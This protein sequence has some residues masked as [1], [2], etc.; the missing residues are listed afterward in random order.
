MA[1]RQAFIAPLIV[2]SAFQRGSHRLSTR[3]TRPPAIA[4][5]SLSMV[6]E[7]DSNTQSKPQPSIVDAADF[8]AGPPPKHLA[9]DPGVEA[10][11]VDEVVDQSSKPI[12]PIASDATKFDSPQPSESTNS[13]SPVTPESSERQQ[14]LQ[15]QIKEPESS[16]QNKEVEASEEKKEDQSSE[17]PT[18]TKATI[19]LSTEQ[20]EKARLARKEAEKKAENDSGA[21]KEQQQRI[22]AR[23]QQICSA[24]GTRTRTFE[25]GER[26]R[27]SLDSALQTAQTAAEKDDVNTQAKL[28]ASAA[29]AAQ[30]LGK[31]IGNGWNTSTVPWLKKNVLPE[32]FESVT[33]P[34]VAATTLAALLTIVA[35]PSLFSA[36]QPAKQAPK[37][38]LEA[39]TAALEK[40][41]QKQRSV[42][43]AYG[44]RSKTQ[45][46]LFPPPQEPQQAL[47]IKT[48]SPP[49]PSD[50][51]SRVTEPSTTTTASRVA[52]AEKTDTTVAAPSTSESTPK[53]SPTQ[54]KVATAPVPAVPAIADVTPSMVMT[55][56]SKGLGS[57]ASLVLS[58]S[59]DTLEA[60]PTIVLEVSKAYHKLPAL[61]QKRIAQ[62]VLASAQSLGYQRVSLVESGNGIEV[63]HA[64]VDVRLEDENENLRAELAAMRAVSEKLAVRT[65]NN[66]AEI[67]KLEERLLEERNQFAGQKTE[68]EKS[69]ASLRAENT[70]LMDDIAAANSEI[71]K[72]PDRFE[73]EQR[74]LEAEQKA[75]KFSDSV[76]M[77]SIQVAKARQAEAE[78]KQSERGALRAVED[79]N[80]ERDS[81][82]AS[83]SQKIEKAQRDAESKA[84]QAI[85][86]AQKEAQVVKEDSEKKVATLEGKLQDSENQSARVLADTSNSY[87]KQLEKEKA[88]NQK[89][90]QS[91]QQKYENLLDEI[92]KKANTELDAFQ[93]SAD[94]KLN[95][96]MKE[97][98]A[99][100]NA[101][102]KE[103]DQAKKEIEKLE[104]KAQREASKTQ[105]EKDALQ[106]RISKLEMKLKEKLVAQ[107]NSIIPEAQEAVDAST[108]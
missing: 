100:V 24:V 107:S 29:K 77:M 52:S 38:Q 40:K 96:A 5:R 99:N 34:A 106:S 58:S 33:P 3:V 48:Q 86:L 9:P 71:S 16:K 81:A 62:V 42:S 103:R 27:T 37:K 7:A 21:R 4:T 54:S 97:A 36:G 92:Q 28:R 87:E 85:T 25:L 75:E 17:K 13:N 22:L 95:A 82:L 56:V 35:I 15:K 105:R 61:E 66:E 76:D 47:S 14:I 83:V 93:K 26:A 31:A 73:L 80:K 20:V 8:D 57:N 84:D 74:T 41:L 50:T 65:A 70:G 63:A 51:T 43:S 11:V 59:F 23:A 39:D 101:V 45:S 2:P 88:D 1:P 32:A 98:T 79:A 30:A 55:S 67:A 72:M 69:V 90:V 94:S 108:K 6:A 89:E 64:G 104:A 44:G 46:E 10:A 18:S 49:K 91:I 102:A 12:T 53:P 68:L 19:T 60:E 78:A